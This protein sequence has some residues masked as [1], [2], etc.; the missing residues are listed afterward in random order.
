MMTLITTTRI[1]P[2]DFKSASDLI[3][4]ISIKVVTPVYFVNICIDIDV[5]L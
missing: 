4:N 3:R 5:T 1:I 2:M